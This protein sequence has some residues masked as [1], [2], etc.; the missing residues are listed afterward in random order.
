[1][2][3]S[4]LNYSD[5]TVTLRTW[6]GNMGDVGSWAVGVIC[7]DRPDVRLGDTADIWQ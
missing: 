1:M 4:K 6:G 3:A 7:G 5:S 2:P